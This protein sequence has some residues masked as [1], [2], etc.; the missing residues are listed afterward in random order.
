MS[1]M[2]MG[3]TQKWTA[4]I[5]RW[6]QLAQNANQ[7]KFLDWNDFRSEFRKE[8]TPAHT[9]ALAINRLKSSAYYQRNRSLDDYI[10][11]FQD[12]IV[13]SVATTQVAFFAI[14]GNKLCKITKIFEEL[15]LI[16][17]RWVIRQL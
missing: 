3:R 10:D 1:Y 8:F 4:Q 15:D 16:K 17:R 11:E 14:F 9:D 6:E 7:T 12:L 13:D 5:F 2:K